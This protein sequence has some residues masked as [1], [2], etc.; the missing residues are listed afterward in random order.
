[1]TAMAM[2][3]TIAFSRALFAFAGVLVSLPALAQAIPEQRFPDVTDVKVRAA[4]RDALAF[5]FD[6]TVSSPYDT[7]SRY[8]DAF[9][10]SALSGQV[11]GERILLHD[12]QNEQPFTRDLYNVRIPASVSVVVVQARD[13]KHGYGGKSVQVRLPGR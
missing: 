10:V 5:D 9:R 8:A 4:S 1:M 11:L 13:R 7:P 2:S 6:V 12:H 3:T